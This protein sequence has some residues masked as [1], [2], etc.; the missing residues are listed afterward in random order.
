[1]KLICL[2]FILPLILG[3]RSS[4]QTG[5]TASA[6][7]TSGDLAIA[8]TTT[9]SISL[10]S[11]PASGGTAPYAYQWYRSRQSRFKADAATVMAGQT[12][13]NFYDAELEPA[14][15][16]YYRLVTTDAAGQT[17]VSAQAADTTAGL[18][19]GQV[20][21]DGN[22]MTQGADASSRA[23]NYPSVLARLLGPNWKVTNVG[24]G[25]RATPAQIAAA[26]AKVDRLYDQD[27]FPQ[28]QV[29]VCWEGTNDLFLHH[30]LTAADAYSHFIAYC[31]A[32][33]AVGWKTLI[34]TL[35][36]RSET[37]VPESFESRRVALNA[38][39]RGGWRTFADGLVDVAA[40]TRIGISGA[41]ENGAFFYQGSGVGDTRV[42]L[43]DAGYALI[44]QYVLGGVAEVV[45]G[46]PQ[47]GAAA[48]Q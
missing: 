21:C 41:E 14:T 27:A 16:Y 48:N 4:G 24:V 17:A 8:S 18:V 3:R 47:T 37:G 15:P 43:V 38:L 5:V 11:L 30:T 39:I 25:A 31:Q 45:S 12:A 20:V 26:P 7:L 40:D 6:P 32:R 36:P 1:M 23:E 10:S 34:L 44:A 33:R 46:S 19:R 9:S 2:L 35:L 22:S 13:L 28:G 42:H 29:V